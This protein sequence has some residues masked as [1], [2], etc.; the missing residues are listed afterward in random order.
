MADDAPA[1]SNAAFPIDRK[2]WVPQVAMIVTFL[3]T[4]LTSRLW[5][6]DIP[7]E[8]QLGISG[9][10]TTTVGG[11]AGWIVPMARK[12]ITSRMTNSL[13]AEAQNDLTSKVDLRKIEVIPEAGLA[14][15][16]AW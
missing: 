16:V 7:A 4:T 1:V 15:E 14:A 11:L 10:L 8:I 3:I 6:I 2:V 12:E 5:G 13:V 9:L